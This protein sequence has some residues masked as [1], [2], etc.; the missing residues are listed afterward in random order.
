MLQTQDE[1]TNLKL[2]NIQ[3]AQQIELIKKDI[4]QFKSQQIPQL[5]INIRETQLQKDKLA[6]QIVKQR[7]MLKRQKDEMT[8]VIC[9][10]NAFY[11]RA[12]REALGDQRE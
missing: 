11:V 12:R 5:N 1:I 8:R 2:L 6:V 3:L 4:N 10:S 7:N 9:E